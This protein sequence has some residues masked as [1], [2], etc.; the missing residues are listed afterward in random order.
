MASTTSR[1][2]PT[3]SPS[4]ASIAVTIASVRTPA[5]APVA[6]SAAASRRASASVF[7][8]AP[9]PAL[10]SSARPPMPSAIF[11]LMI[12]AVMSGTLST[13]AVTSRSAYSRPSAGAMAAVC[14]TSAQ[15]TVASARLM[16]A[17]SRVTRKPGID[18]SLSRVPPVW[19]SARPDIIGTGAPHAAASGARTSEVLSPT[20]P[21]LCLSTGR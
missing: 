3:A 2:L 5:R 4:G 20:P 6:T 8:K 7:M 15:P 18:S 16:A 14:P 9:R 12:E 19:P 11:L 10:T 1:A 21:V 13:V 17:S